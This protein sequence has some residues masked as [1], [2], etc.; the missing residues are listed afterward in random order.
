MDDKEV[1][2]LRD[3]ANSLLFK[4]EEVAAI[5]SLE[6]EQ[7]AVEFLSQVKH[8]A[9][10]VDD[11]RRSYTDPLNAAVKLIK[12]DFDTIL[13]PLD[14]AEVVVKKGIQTFRDAE[15][16]RRKEAARKEAE[17]AAKNAVQPIAR[18]D[19]SPEAI[20]K[21]QEASVAL[22]QANAVAPRTVTTQTGQLRTRK[23]WKFEVVAPLDVPRDYCSPDAAIIRAAVKGG[24]REI[25]GI[26]IWEETTPIIVA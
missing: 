15:D 19:M 6:T 3:D 8:R 2:Q 7:R 23:D 9:K 21:A 14:Q 17:I 16:F 12:A 5:D 26:R 18:G 22:Q 13:N 11:K 25:P 10:I 4:A 24:E 20:G 1:A